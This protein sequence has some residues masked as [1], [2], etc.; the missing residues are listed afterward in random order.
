LGGVFARKKQ[1]AKTVRLLQKKKGGYRKADIIRVG[2]EIRPSQEK[3]PICGRVLGAS[4]TKKE[5][6]LKSLNLEEG[7]GEGIR[8]KVMKW[9]RPAF[10]VFLA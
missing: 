6:S 1:T 8:T 5:T 3:G 9:L 7:N 4:R 2:S 10:R